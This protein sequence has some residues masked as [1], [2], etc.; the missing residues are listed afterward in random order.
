M[1]DSKHAALAGLLMVC[2][3]SLAQLGCSTAPQSPE[4]AVSGSG[5]AGGQ[6]AAGSTRPRLTL[7][8]SEEE[9][10][11]FRSG[12]FLIQA[13]NPAQPDVIRGGQGRFEWVSLTPKNNPGN[14]REREILMWFGPLGRNLG[15][16]QREI[17][18]TGVLTKMGLQQRPRVQ[19]FNSEGFA[20]DESEQQRLMYELLGGQSNML[21]PRQLQEALNLLMDS[22]AL[23]GR[24]TESP[25]QFRFRIQETEVTLRAVLDPS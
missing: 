8:Q 17:G 6:P 22:M 4:R 25:R 23:V 13:N 7:E 15:S 18:P 20:L 12:R 16:F 24:S 1:R 9:L 2:V 14:A 10:R 21:N 19:A 11:H 5:Q 3:A